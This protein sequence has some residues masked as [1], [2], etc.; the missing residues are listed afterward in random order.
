MYQNKVSIYKTM[1]KFDKVKIRLIKRLNY[2]KYNK[3]K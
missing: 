3:V 2:R 1:L